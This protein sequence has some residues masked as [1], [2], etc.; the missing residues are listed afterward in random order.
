MVASSN[1]EL[2]F[3]ISGSGYIIVEAI[4][5]VLYQGAPNN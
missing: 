2:L 1:F 3:E 4:K 5:N